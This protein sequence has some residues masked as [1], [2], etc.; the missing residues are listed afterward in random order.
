MLFR[1]S[2]QKVRSD[3]VGHSRLVEKRKKIRLCIGRW[4]KKKTE[5][6]PP[7]RLKAAILGLLLLM[8]AAYAGIL[9]R[10]MHFP[11]AGFEIPFPIRVPGKVI[12]ANPSPSVLDTLL[13]NK[14]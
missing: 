8:L 14:K 13:N 11:V 12:P 6:V 2:K 4:L 5:R 9:F 10:V 3:P 7:A 1:N